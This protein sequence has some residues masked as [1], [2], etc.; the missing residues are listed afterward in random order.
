MDLPNEFFTAE[1][2]FTMSGATGVTFV[3]SNGLQRAFNFNPRW[4][5]F[6]IA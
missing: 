5:A 2:M 4:L 6:V 1:S 3:V